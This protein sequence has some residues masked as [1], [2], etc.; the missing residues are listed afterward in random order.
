M[1]RVLEKSKIWTSV[2]ARDEPRAG[3]GKGQPFSLTRQSCA[4]RQAGWI[5]KGERVQKHQE[6]T[7]TECLLCAMNSFTYFS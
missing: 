2:G 5:W 1:S 4:H 7:F 6:L 3:P